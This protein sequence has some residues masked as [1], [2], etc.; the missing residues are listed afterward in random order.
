MNTGF[1]VGQFITERP[2]GEGGMAEVWLGRNLHLSTPVAIKFLNEQ[3]AAR[4]DVQAR[5]LN[6]GKRQGNL[7]HP[8]I[9]KV[10]GFDYVGTQGFLILQ[11]IEGE[12]LDVRLQRGLL[13]RDET[14]EIANGVLSALS[15]AHAAGVVHRD[16][17]PSNI[18]LN[19]NGHPYLGDF[20]IV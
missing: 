8:N 7:D 11:Y 9:V 6:E 14:L 16:V 19:R 2:L 17:K 1:K 20:G 12:P 18:L 10:F 4:Q 15:F 3:Y 13:N 5:F